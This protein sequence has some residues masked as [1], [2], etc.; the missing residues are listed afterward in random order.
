MMTS[1]G[2]TTMENENYIPVTPIL[3]NKLTFNVYIGGTLIL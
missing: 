2:P 3:I 1:V